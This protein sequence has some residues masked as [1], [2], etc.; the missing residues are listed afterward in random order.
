MVLQIQPL[1][2]KE[3]LVFLSPYR[4]R[5]FRVLLSRLRGKGVTVVP[6][7]H[8]DGKGQSGIFTGEPWRTDG[9]EEDW[10]TDLKEFVR[11]SFP[12]G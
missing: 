6:V 1:E 10:E 8:R 12:A 4:E 11:R 7:T 3:E 2:E 9:T 5:F